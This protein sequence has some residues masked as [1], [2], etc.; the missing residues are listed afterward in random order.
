V[1]ERQTTA[2][3]V[4]SDGFFADPYPEYERV[5][6]VAPVHEHS[7]GMWFALRYDDVAKILRDQELSVEDRTV[8]DTPRNRMKSDVIGERWME[9][10]S[11]ARSDPPRHTELRR[12][13]SRPFT[14]RAIERRRMAVERILAD[15]LAPFGQGDVLDVVAEIGRPMPYR[16]MCDFLGIPA[17]GDDEELVAASHVFTLASMEP[18]PTREQVAASAVGGRLLHEHLA[19]VCAWKREHP[20]DDLVTD[21][22]QA[23]ADG[24]ITDG[25]LV[26]MVLAL[27]IAGH[28]T[29]VSA[30]AL[31]VRSLLLHPDQ[32]ALLVREPDLLANAVEELLRYDPTVQLSWRSTRAPYQVGEH[33]VPG[34]VHLLA[35]EGSANRDRARWDSPDTLDL[36]RADARDHLSFG[37]GA[38]LCLGAW[39]ARSELGVVL[40][41]LTHHFPGMQLEHDAVRWEPLVAIRN[42]DR[43]VVRL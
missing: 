9:R 6:D 18:F 14:P 1:A 40:A 43:V 35:W 16:A 39:L 36:R 2:I 42:P 23:E 26:E 30:I 32:W 29:T 27:F 22:V 15:L 13:V 37:A 24:R 34:G 11:L 3:D 21:L 12:L 31:A 10:M 4:H 38:H 7:E 19:E 8:P 17:T 28:Q 25:D 20:G 5:R 41:H 33:E